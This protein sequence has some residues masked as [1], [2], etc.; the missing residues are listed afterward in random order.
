[1]NNKSFGELKELVLE[2]ADDKDLLHSEN[3]DVQFGKFIEEVFEFKS[4]FDVWKLYKK[5]KY[6]EKIEQDFSI[7]EVER[8]KNLKLEMGDIFVTLIILCEDLGIDPTVCL[9]MAYKKISKRRG[10]T[11]N[12]TFVKSEDL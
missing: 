1:M 7:E 10:R 9:E 5:F 3:A 11:I 2:W 8:W 4:E 6:D 12:G